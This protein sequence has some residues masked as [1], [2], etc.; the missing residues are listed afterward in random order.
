[1]IIWVI[2]QNVP[3]FH[4]FE[5]QNMILILFSFIVYTSVSLSQSSIWICNHY[6]PAL[7]IPLRAEEKMC[8]GL[9][10]K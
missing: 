4:L 1:M 10:I 5:A 9:P 7:F 2:I 6:Y 3:P 8:T